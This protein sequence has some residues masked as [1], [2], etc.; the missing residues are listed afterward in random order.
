[1]AE[2]NVFEVYKDA[3][4]AKVENFGQSIQSSLNMSTERKSRRRYRMD[5]SI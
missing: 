2:L 4:N 5:R 3:N 1:M